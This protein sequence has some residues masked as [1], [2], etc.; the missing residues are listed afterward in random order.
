M[1][2]HVD[3]DVG[4][5]RVDEADDLQRLAV[6]LHGE[7]PPVDLERA[8]DGLGTLDGDHVRLDV[9]ALR[10]AAGE[11]RGDDWAVRFGEMIAY[12]RSKGWTDDDGKVVRAHI[13]RPGAV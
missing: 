10:R 12:A 9:D 13:D 6:V 7:G 1:N 5:H 11:G 2:V 8:L 4:S 3:L